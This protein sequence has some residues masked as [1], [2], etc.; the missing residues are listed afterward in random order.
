MKRKKNLQKSVLSSIDPRPAKSCLAASGRFSHSGSHMLP[1][2]TN[3]DAIKH[4]CQYY[5]NITLYEKTKH[6]ALDAN[7]S[8]RPKTL[9]KVI[10]GDFD[11]FYMDR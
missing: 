3:A 6:N 10:I 4:N 11:S 1:I 8:Y 5:K 9:P 2:E 7:L